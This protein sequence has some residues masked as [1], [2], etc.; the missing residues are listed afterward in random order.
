MK[1]LSVFLLLSAFA[2]MAFSA[3][4]EVLLGSTKLARHHT[5]IDFIKA[6][7]CGLSEIQIRVE[8]RAADIEHIY[9]EY[10]N[11]MPDELEVRDRI[12][13]GGQ[14]RWINLRGL[15]DRC[16]QKIVVIGDS[17]GRAGKRSLVSVF[18]S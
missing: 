11:G 5:D 7:K 15:G 13:R 17:E 8:Q 6:N 3:Q 2:S 9:V 16:I 10:G 1:K 4:A 18:Y 14:T 12:R